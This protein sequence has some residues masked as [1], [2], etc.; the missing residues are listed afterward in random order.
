M[1]S[2]DSHRDFENPPSRRRE[3]RGTPGLGH[4][5][6]RLWLRLHCRVTWQTPQTARLQ[7]R[8]PRLV[9]AARSRS[10]AGR[11]PGSSHAHGNAVGD[12]HGRFHSRK[13]ST[14]GRQIGRASGS[15][16]DY[17]WSSHPVRPTRAAGVSPACPQAGRHGRS[18]PRGAGRWRLIDSLQERPV[19]MAQ[20][21]ARVRGRECPRALLGRRRLDPMRTAT[22]TWR[23]GQTCRMG[24]G[25]STLRPATP[26]VPWRCSI[27]RG[28]LASLGFSRVSWPRMRAVSDPGGARWRVVEP[29]SPGP[30]AATR[31]AC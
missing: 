12:R 4:D 23:S 26:T 14:Q 5:N 3:R 15:P 6:H 19:A 30:V 10:M 29:S 11:Q 7:G 31:V 25:G 16:L 28:G 2:A 8:S 20:S 1:G 18:C 9:A 17:R 13:C 21:V 24:A 22:G 27:G